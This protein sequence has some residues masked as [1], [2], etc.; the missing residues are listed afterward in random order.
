MVLSGGRSGG[1]FGERENGAGLESKIV[2]MNELEAIF[3]L[4]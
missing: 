4:R 3:R 2:E 1:L